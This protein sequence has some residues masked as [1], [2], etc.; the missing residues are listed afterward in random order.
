MLLFL[1]WNTDSILFLW[2]NDYEV[3]LL[4]ISLEFFFNQD[5]FDIAFV[6]DFRGG[7]GIG[8]G[9]TNVQ[10]KQNIDINVFF[11]IYKLINMCVCSEFFF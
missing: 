11:L 2:I 6:C 10:D 3:F 5:E 7:G 8:G 4:I 1:D 9:N